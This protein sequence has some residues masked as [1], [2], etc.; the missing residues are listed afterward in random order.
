MFYSSNGNFIIKKK[1]VENFEPISTY[2][3]GKALFGG[4]D[5]PA[6]V[7][8]K[9][10]QLMETQLVPQW[11]QMVKKQNDKELQDFHKKVCDQ[12][13]KFDEMEKKMTYDMK[14]NLEIPPDVAD[15]FLTS[16][17]KNKKTNVEFVTYTKLCEIASSE[18]ESREALKFRDDAIKR[19]A[20]LEVSDNRTLNS[21]D[22][23]VSR[24]VAA[25][26]DSFT[27][28]KSQ[29][30][31][32]T[33]SATALREKERAD[34]AEQELARMRIQ[35]IRDKAAAAKAAAAKAA[36]AGLQ[37]NVLYIIAAVV[38]YLLINKS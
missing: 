26:Q 22:S 2:F 24:P 25:S 34:K 38:I 20:S 10:R 15:K 7:D 33:R 11:N 36:A 37:I 3:I 23:V 9:V 27:P 19:A 28:T 16:Y 31:A 18:I 32:A 30:E 6:V 4:N 21:G 29:L 17:K 5:K 1:H 12:K 8:D 35:E 14:S 13:N